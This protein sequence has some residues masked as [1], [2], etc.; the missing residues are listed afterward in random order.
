MTAEQSAGPSLFAA[1]A[2]TFSTRLDQWWD[3]AVLATLR[4]ARELGGDGLAARL[5]LLVSM[6]EAHDRAH[7]RERT[8]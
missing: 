1:Q 8:S 5:E 4:E 7:G 3:T 2:G 6:R